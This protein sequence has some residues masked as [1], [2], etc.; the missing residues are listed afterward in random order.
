MT[1]HDWER[2]NRAN[3]VVSDKN[4]TEEELLDA[5]AGIQSTD[6]PGLGDLHQE[7]QRRL[8]EIERVSMGG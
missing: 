7:L 1:R 2:F 8:R 4:A 5:I 3:L 6:E